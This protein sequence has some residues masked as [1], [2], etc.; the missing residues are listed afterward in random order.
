MAKS[1]LDVQ[2]STATKEEQNA[3]SNE[4]HADRSAG[5]SSR[6]SSL[7][8]PA[9]SSEEKDATKQSKPPMLKLV[10][11]FVSVFF[12]VFLMALNGSIL[13]TVGSKVSIF[14]RVLI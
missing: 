12:S 4:Q 7:D 1:G 2:D 11:L 3:G 8:A 10:T 5:D 13:A 9:P 14:S 6:R